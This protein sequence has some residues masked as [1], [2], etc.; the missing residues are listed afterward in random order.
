MHTQFLTSPRRSPVNRRYPP[1]E[2][3]D[4]K[5]ILDSVRQLKLPSENFVILGSAPMV[6]HGILPTIQKDVDILARNSAWKQAQK[7]AQESG[8]LEEDAKLVGSVI[9]LC[10]NKI[11]IY[12]DWPIPD[13]SVDQ[14]INDRDFFE[15]YRLPFAKL[16][17][18]VA[19]KQRLNRTKDKEHLRLYEQWKKRAK[20]RGLT[21]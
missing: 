11:E 8:I 5:H 2:Q 16:K 19:Y 6:I 3:I 7:I 18:V 15:E 12:N 10:N 21:F 14:M 9:R 1:E 13:I 4:P 17:Y 20:T